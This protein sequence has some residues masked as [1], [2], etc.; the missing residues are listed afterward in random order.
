MQY[1]LRVLIYTNTTSQ[2]Y[3]ADVMKTLKVTS[4]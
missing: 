3:I 1:A 4:L 2:V